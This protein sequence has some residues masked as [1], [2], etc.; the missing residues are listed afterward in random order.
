[1][2]SVVSCAGCAGRRVSS[3]VSGLGAMLCD[4]EL[5]RYCGEVGETRCRMECSGR[6]DQLQSAVA[7]TTTAAE[8]VQARS[9]L[10]GSITAVV[11]T[12]GV[13]FP[14]ALSQSLTTRHRSSFGLPLS[15]F[16][17]ASSFLPHSLSHIFSD[18]P[19]LSFLSLPHTILSPPQPPYLPLPAGQPCPSPD[20]RDRPA[21]QC[22][23][24]LRYV[25]APSPN[26]HRPA[27]SGARAAGLLAAIRR[28]AAAAARS[29]YIPC[30]PRRRCHFLLRLKGQVS[31][32]DQPY[33]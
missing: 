33:P 21:V 7:A 1:M 29:V 2:S 24:L 12:C 16:D 27:G 20:R 19:L 30:P 14:C 28:P 9:E 31:G 22:R 13:C 8:T 10:C 17:S 5:N 26:K 3:P 23:A 11:S 18:F 25:A 15:A 4:L 32:G 6:H